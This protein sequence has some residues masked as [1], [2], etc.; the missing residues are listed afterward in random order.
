[1]RR[2]GSERRAA[3]LA[4]A[5]LVAW[6]CGFP[7]HEFVP[8][9]EFSG[10]R[11][12]ASGA[13]GATA[14]GAGGTSGAGAVGGTGGASAA[15]GAGGTSAEGG[16]AGAG[17]GG[18]LGGASASA[19][20]G[21]ASGDGGTSV[22]G[23]GGAAAQGGADASAGASGAAGASAS[24]GVGGTGGVDAS[25]DATVDAG[26][27]LGLLLNEVDYDQPSTDTREFVEIFNPTAADVD[28]A[29]LALLFVNGLNGS[30]YG[31]IPL[32]GTLGAGQYLVAA[33]PAVVVAD[34]GAIVIP[35]T[36]TMQNGAPEGVAIYDTVKKTVVDAL[37]YEGG[38]FAA[39]VDG[40]TLNLVDGTPATA[41]DPDSSE[42]SLARLPN[43][44][45]TKN[46]DADWKL[47]ANLTP[48]APN[49]P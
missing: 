49:L 22:A 41:S 35:L 43:G 19:G 18:G 21:G 47:T 40:V 2:F 26:A 15:G 33:M 45:D 44:T 30:E 12:A 31:R 24:G 3:A 38:I 29:G 14:G 9:D 39:N 32:S 36:V 17:G 34:A 48:G 7:D 25:V 20:D 46:D 23:Q 1:M 4:G 11:D 37:S 16:V 28:L 6:A 13:A 27:P 5:G 10:R 8:A 42:R